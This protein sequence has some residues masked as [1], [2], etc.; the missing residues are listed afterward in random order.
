MTFE[1]AQVEANVRAL[2]D[3]VRDAL[4]NAGTEAN[5]AADEHL[6]SRRKK[7]TKTSAVDKATLSS[8]DGL[9]IPLKDL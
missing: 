1:V 5:T 7:N 9:A 3:S 8:L 2:V 4:S 6:V